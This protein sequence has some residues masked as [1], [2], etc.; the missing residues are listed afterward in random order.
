MA[1]LPT[2]QNAGVGSRLI[3]AGIEQLARD[4]QPFAVVRGHPHYYPR[5]I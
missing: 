4:G 5:S 1:V 3:E 2:H